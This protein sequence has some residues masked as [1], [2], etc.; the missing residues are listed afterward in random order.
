MKHNEPL[1]STSVLIIVLVLLLTI[2]CGQSPS[3]AMEN[4]SKANSQ[5]QETITQ[6]E[7]TQAQVTSSKKI[8][9][10]FGYTF[11]IPS[12]WKMGMNDSSR[13][14]LSIDL[15]KNKDKYF[16]NPLL[17]IFKPDIQNQTQEDFIK[18]SLKG[19]TSNIKNN[20]VTNLTKYDV[21]AYSCTQ[22]SAHKDYSCYYAFITTE[23]DFIVVQL[24]GDTSTKDTLESVFDNTIKSLKSNQQ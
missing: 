24:I 8:D 6:D 1:K 5:V 20:D 14:E 21:S 7:H 9:S 13:I 11:A 10:E 22:S 12:G 3:Q 23:K 19:T 4:Q 18:N 16:V 17:T 15:S 2:G